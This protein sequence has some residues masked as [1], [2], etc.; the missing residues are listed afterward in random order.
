MPGSNAT[1]VIPSPTSF[2]TDL[3]K[4][5][6]AHFEAL[7]AEAYIIIHYSIL[8]L[9]NHFLPHKVKWVYKLQYYHFFNIQTYKQQ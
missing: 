8:P 3:V 2:A 5:S 1:I 7:Y 6:I 4:P 9:Q